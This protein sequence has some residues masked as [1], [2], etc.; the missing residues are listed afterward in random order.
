M[1]RG[2][3]PAVTTLELSA[4]FRRCCRELVPAAFETIAELL[5]HGE[6][7]RVRLEAARLILDYAALKPPEQ[8]E[9]TVSPD[10]ARKVQAAWARRRE[11]L[12]LA[13]GTSAP[14]AQSL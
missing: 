11:Q 13:G 5:K 1:E 3:E 10:W 2:A 7:E 14:A 9:L 4:G 12:A 8:H 6:H